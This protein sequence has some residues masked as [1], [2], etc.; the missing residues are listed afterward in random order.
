[1]K[2]FEIRMAN[3]RKEHW[4]KVYRSKSLQ[5]M[6][7]YQQEPETSL[8]LI[9]EA[10]VGPNARI[11]DVGGGD[12]L[13][14]DRLLDLGYNKVTVL[15]ISEEALARARRRLGD[16][17]HLV[18]WICS[19]ATSF[20]A[21]AHYDLWH[22]R[23]CFHFLTADMEVEAYLSTLRQGLGAG[24]W[25]ILGG[26]SNTGPVKCSGL[27]VRRQGEEQLADLLQQDFSKKGCR[28][29]RHITPSGSVQN[30]IFCSF[31][32]KNRIK[33]KF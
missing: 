3:E 6:G 17:A 15:D 5:E 8:Q 2:E 7:W 10:G 12:S 29:T 9:R 1:M 30:Y 32:K 27:E 11:I 33:Q 16:R 24:G 13:L 22:D 21:D 28:H 23:A 4:E 20:R 26:F 25:F 14:V 18:N 19:D 31:L